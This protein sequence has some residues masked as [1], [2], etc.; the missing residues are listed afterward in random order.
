MRDNIHHNTIEA[1]YNI[2]YPSYGTSSIAHILLAMS[3]LLKNKKTDIVTCYNTAAYQTSF[4]AMPS[5]KTALPKVTA[6]DMLVYIP[7]CIH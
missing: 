2:V 7:N 6:S 3:H 5:P 4:I 1:H